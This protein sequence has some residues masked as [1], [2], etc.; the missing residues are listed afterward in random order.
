VAPH[1]VL[2]LHSILS[3]HL[4]AADEV[5]KGERNGVSEIEREGGQKERKE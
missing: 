5:K 3:D 2:D 4:I 1:T